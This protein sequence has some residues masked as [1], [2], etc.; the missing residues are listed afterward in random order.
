MRHPFIHLLVLV[1]LF[2]AC[3]AGCAAIVYGEMYWM[4]FLITTADTILANS[5]YAHICRKEAV[6]ELLKERYA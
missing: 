2:F 3:A 1:L 4:A 5:I 6:N